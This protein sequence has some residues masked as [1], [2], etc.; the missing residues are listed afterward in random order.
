MPVRVFRRPGRRVRVLAALLVT[1]SM[2]LQVGFQ[3]AAK[4]ATTSTTLDFAI[5]RGYDRAELEAVVA[6]YNG[7]NDL[8]SDT[9][10]EEFDGH[11]GDFPQIQADDWVD[12][13]G[14]FTVTST[15][16]SV[17]VESD[18]VRTNITWTKILIGV[19]AFSI[20]MV[21]R[22]TCLLTLNSMGLLAVSKP[23][24]G[25]IWG[26][27][28]TVLYN[29][30]SD[31]VDGVPLDWPHIQDAVA[32][33]VVGGIFT[34]AWELGIGNYFNTRTWGE[35]GTDVVDLL[36]QAA[37]K[38]QGWWGALAGKMRQF[39]GWLNGKF[40]SLADAIRNYARDKGLIRGTTDLR[41]LPLGDSITY[42]EGGS[43]LDGVGY[44]GPLWSE[45]DDDTSNLDFVG[46]LDS[47]E[48]RIPDTDHEGHR[49]WRI[50]QIAAVATDCA[51]GRYAPNVV[52]LN[53]GTNDLDKNEDIAGAP[54]R[55]QD[56]VERITDM[57]PLTTVIVSGL[58]GSLDSTV[59]DR[60][61]VYNRFLQTIVGTLRLQGRRV[62]F[63]DPSSIGL[64]RSD[65]FDRLHPND[66]GYRK[67]ANAYHNAI[68]TAMRAGE[69][70][71][72]PPGNGNVCAP[73]SASPTAGN[74]ANA[75]MTGWDRFEGWGGMIAA[76][77]PGGTREGLRFADLD[78][79]GRDDYLMADSQG[80]VSA[81]ANALPSPRWA[82]MGEVAAG[83]PGGTRE[84]LRF[85]D[86]D[87]DGRDDYLMIDSQGGVRAWGNVLPSKR[88]TEWGEVAAGV[89]GATREEVRFADIDGDG[90]DDYLLVSPQGQ[91][92][93]WL[94]NLPSKTW[95][96]WGV[97]APGFGVSRDEVRFAD[98]D[99][100]G[101]DDYLA[102]NAQGR[103]RAWLNTIGQSGGQS[104]FSLGEIASGV[105]MSR[106]DV[107]FADVDG[108]GSADYLAANGSAQ[109]WAWLGA[110]F[111]GAGRWS[112]QGTI[113]AGV[114]GATLAD[115]RFADLNGDRRTD[116][117]LVDPQGRVQAWINDLPSPR[118]IEWGQVAAGVAGGT[119][120]EVRFADLNC[121]GRDD[122]LLVDPQGRVRGWLNVL[123]G[124]TWTDWGQVAAG[125]SGGTRDNLRFADVDGDGCD[126][127]LMVGPQGQ[128]HAWSNRLPSKTW[129][130]LG[131]IA[132]GIGL[133]NSTI[134]FADID[135]DG[136]DDYLSVS[137]RGRIW[138]WRNTGGSTWPLQGEITTGL[139]APSRDQVFLGDVNGDRR[140]DYLLST[141]TGAVTAWLG[142]GQVRKT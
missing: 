116:Y 54:G 93:A 133:H 15:G 87:G 70:T 121:D 96:E 42:G 76:G 32:I 23:V 75:V 50:A 108:D 89:P 44:R 36:N 77:V 6:E 8:L 137:D 31:Y 86:L 21:L 128:V 35:L 12:F 19:A 138:G 102:V 91:V 11:R 26:F 101:R 22:V 109:V 118:W 104:W 56:T 63:V 126:D 17:T 117:L 59:N 29:L 111:A 100:D 38:I 13:D 81:W 99:G 55:L 72:T 34:A 120:E 141:S 94:N 60:M 5:P 119:R 129:A 46:S 28:G 140:L 30:I 95:T 85:A 57:S 78:G 49:G 67:M 74:P 48:G 33:G 66:S 10:K 24:C 103:V 39:G 98:I 83:V 114:P 61:T 9:I 18:E 69:I 20:G 88:W 123:P 107:E 79:D 2:L 16:L 110:R 45:L 113:A 27:I 142:S 112:P 106:A 73:D 115:L 58:V 40:S 105:G 92:R 51:I 122:Y 130:D 136:R 25:F 139:R 7:R 47:G 53:A 127:Y 71:R 90:T 84:G 64:T 125:V 68:K 62:Q 80:R 132:A 4:A 124:K 52:I 131:E 3:P 37:N 14:E 97:V 135:G 65:F 43:D 1:L 82:E 134:T 41:V